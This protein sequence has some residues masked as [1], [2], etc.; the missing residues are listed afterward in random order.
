MLTLC[1]CYYFIIGITAVCTTN[2]CVH[3]KTLLKNKIALSRWSRDEDDNADVM[4]EYDAEDQHFDDEAPLKGGK[5]KAKAS[6]SS[7]RSLSLSL[8]LSF[9][10]SLS[11]SLSLPV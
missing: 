10:L 11:L 2:C 4:A 9:S 6:S 7:S 3:N 1:L 8:S 5:G